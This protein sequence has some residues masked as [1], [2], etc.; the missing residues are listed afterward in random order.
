MKDFFI[1]GRLTDPAGGTLHSLPLNPPLTG[2]DYP[3]I[4]FIDLPREHYID[5]TF[6]T[7][8]GTVRFHGPK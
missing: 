1:S 3:Q 4:F 5:L 2:A 6:T 8:T 7:W